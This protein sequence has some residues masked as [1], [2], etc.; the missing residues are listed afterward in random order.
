MSHTKLHSN[1]SAQYKHVNDIIPMEPS[2]TNHINKSQSAWW[3]WDIKR[4]NVHWSSSF[5]SMM[6]ISRNEQPDILF[7]VDRLLPKDLI[8]FINFTEKI[9]EDGHPREFTFNIELYDDTWKTIKCE[10]EGIMDEYSGE[11]VQ[12]IGL[13]IDVISR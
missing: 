4:G 6:G 11:V 9:S 12:I 3:M 2:V 5:Y 1:E 8:T 10:M 13:C 7:W